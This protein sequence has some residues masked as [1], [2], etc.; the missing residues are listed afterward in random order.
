M[1]GKEI[2]EN[3]A[4]QE[5]NMQLQD[6]SMH[7]SRKQYEHVQHMLTIVNL[8]QVTNHLRIDAT[9]KCQVVFDGLGMPIL[10]F[11]YKPTF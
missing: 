11:T 5:V 1:G 10:E 4:R 7:V 9:C 8:Y 3:E 2:P 6:I